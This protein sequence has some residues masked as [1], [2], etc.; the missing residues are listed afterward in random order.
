MR[1]T[2]HSVRHNVTTYV[3]IVI[4]VLGG[5]MAYRSLPREAAPE[6]EIPV[7]V[8]STPYV[9]VA[10]EDI[11]SLVT[12]IIEREV[13]EI[14]EIKKL[15]STS[16]EG[17][18][19]VTAEFDT[20]TNLDEALAKIREKVD[21][22]K[23][24][25]PQ[26]A[27]EPIVQ[28]IS[29]TD[30]PMMIVNVTGP[31]SQLALK[32][33]AEDLEDEIEN[34]TGVLEVKVAG[35][36]E[37]EFQ[38][39]VDLARLNHYALTLNDV[40]AAIQSENVNVPGGDVDVGDAKFLVRVPGEYETAKQIANSVV[41]V[42][43]G[44]PI[45]IRDVAEVRDTFKERQTFS[46]L[47]G[48][49]NVSLTITKRAGA[50]I[51]E[52]A[53]GIRRVIAEME[54]AFP[55]NT[56]IVILSDESEN[57]RDMVK[58]LE[59]N[60]ITGLLLVIAV[61]MFAMGFR[62]SILVG[63]AIPLSM[64]ITFLVLQLFGITLNMIVLFSLILALGMLVDNG[65]VIVENIYRHA[66]MG[67]TIREAALEGT[68]EVAWPV[69]TSTFTT[70]AAFLPLM[71]WPGVIGEF[72]GYLP[73][74]LIITLLASL[75]VA[76]VITPVLCAAF[77]RVK[78][79]GSV[80][81]D[82]PE[83]Q[84][85]AD[86][87][88]LAGKVMA[89]YER[90]LRGAIAHRAITVGIGLVVFVVT[91]VLYGMSGL[92]VEFFPETPPERIIISVDAGD[93][94][95]VELTNRVALAIEARIKGNP[96]IEHYV[97]TVGTSGG[98]GGGF[99]VGGGNTPHRAQV[100]IDFVE[101]ELQTAPI[102]DVIEG[103]RERIADI[104]GARIEISKQQN[105]PP[106][107]APV[108]I[109]LR[110]DDLRGLERLTEEVKAIVESV[111]GVVDLKDDFASGRPEVR[112]EVDRE[113]AG[114]VKASTRQIGDVVR[115]A[116][117]GTEASKIRDG[118]DEYDIR[119]RLKEGDRRSLKD[120]E[121]LRIRVNDPDRIA[122]ANLVPIGEIARLVPSGGTGS[123]RH[124][125]K[126]RVVTISANTEGRLANEVV[127]EL[128]ETLASYPMPEGFSYAFTGEQE[129]QAESQAFLGGAFLLALFLIALILVTQF[130]SVFLPAIIMLAVILSLVGVFWGQMIIQLPFGIIMTGLGVI[131]L[132]G[133]VVNNAIVLVDYIQQLRDRGLP[134]DE[135]LIRAGLI[136]LRPVLLTAITT[137]LGLV[138]MALKISIDF[139]TLSV[140]E[141]GSSS[142]FWFPMAIAVIFG[143]A[144]ATV[145]TLVVVPT[146]Y[147]LFD[148]FEGF[149]KRIF[150]GKS[151]KEE[152]LAGAGE[153]S[154][155]ARAPNI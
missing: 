124:K 140:Q 23:A 130:N 39:Q 96:N 120:L 22:A 38:V 14:A 37:R 122:E 144:I 12:N 62:N 145:L 90:I 15:A 58:E 48:R 27:E 70:V 21:L 118:E 7:I 51:I 152:S 141:G 150:G 139:S 40:V 127:A 9:G 138:P 151:E 131:S 134:R 30:F 155:A 55:A 104:P 121:T 28:E 125:E 74:T 95:R 123:I 94:T 65:I 56:E 45:Y 36:I 41:R 64:M 35:G 26:D 49:S 18:S 71:F 33:V 73:K 114:L 80:L 101:Q 47:D 68:A 116:I 92:G 98:G 1:I 43:L 3:L 103:I 83:S 19:I 153:P 147:S 142:A 87:S 109:E 77:L 79:T 91:F 93:G 75:L 42:R 60:M 5:I 85:E 146:L 72:M 24:D 133:V 13:S 135:A 117:N 17:V 89:S 6:I 31:Y 86:T 20:D 25:L 108:N 113:K 67:K 50:N 97:A 46:R 132:A 137:V 99:S 102:N 107:G 78:G 4:F 105:G 154:P 136:R 16:A 34:L 44:V 110:G 10:P 54:D 111:D 81:S 106:T 57:I 112:I 82:D 53:E 2:E 63:L 61:I 32:R 149:L 143:L 69:T 119:V 100:T 84:P 76:L 11:E 88:T 52:M 129:D 115:T 8:V 128:R 126:E 148:D 66:S 29:T 59:N